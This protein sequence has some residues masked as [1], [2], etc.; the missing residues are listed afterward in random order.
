MKFAKFDPIT[1]LLVS[2]GDCPDDEPQDPIDK[3]GLLVFHYK[4][5]L[6]DFKFDHGTMSLVEKPKDALIELRLKLAA[7]MRPP[8]PE[9]LASVGLA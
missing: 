8:T 5:V 6:S 4:G 3:E 9:E 7:E 2:E 1:G